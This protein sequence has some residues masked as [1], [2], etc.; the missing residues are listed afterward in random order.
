[1]S[2][3]TRFL[4]IED[5]SSDVELIQRELKKLKIPFNTDVVQDEEALRNSLEAFKPDI[6]LSDYMLPRFTG[7]EALKVVL[8]FDTE[9]PFIIVTGSMNEQTAVECMKAGAWDYV[10][11]EKL[12]KLLPSIQSALA[13]KELLEDKK[14]ALRSLRESEQRYR[15]LIES[16]PMAIVVHLEKK[17]YYANER[18]IRMAGAKELEDM[19]GLDIMT[20]VHPDF[21]SLIETRFTKMLSGETLDTAEEKFIT[22]DGREIPVE[23][24]SMPV[25]IDGRKAFMSIINDISQRKEAMAS[26][27]NLVEQSND[28]I[29]L[30]FKDKFELIN[31][32]FTEMFGYS[33][34]DCRSDD[35]NFLTLIAPESLPLIQ[36][37]IQAQK[38]GEELTKMY[39]FTAISKTGQRIICETSTSHIE[40][41]GG[42][43]TQGI[44]RDI[45]ERRQA[46]EEI[47]KLSL[48]VEQSPNSI[49]I[50]DLEGT[51]EYVNP[52]FKDITGYSN[53]EAIGE[54]PR[55][56]KSAETDPQV[57]VNLWETLTSGQVWNGRFINR[58]KNGEIFWAKAIISP[59]FDLNKKITHYL[60]LQEDITE[61]IQLEEQFRQSQKMEAIGQLAGGVAHDF[62]NLLTIINGYSELIL[63]KTERESPIFEQ[64]QQIKQAGIRATSL[65]RQLLAFSRKQI[66]KPEILNI[67][68]LIKDMEKMLRRLIGEDIDFISIYDKSLRRIKADPGQ[69]EQVILNLVVN[70]RDAMPDGGKLT[71]E[72]MNIQ[73]TESYVGLH[74]GSVHGW[75][76]MIAVSD[77][78]AG[79][80]NETKE[81]IFEPF[82]TTKEQG[83]G[84]GLGLST[85]YGIVQQSGG[86]VW[87]Y[88][89]EGVGTT[90]KIY[91]PQIEEDELTKNKASHNERELSGIETILI[92][93]DEEFVRELVISGLQEFGYQIISAKNREDA[94]K[95]AREYNGKIDLLLTD[96]VMPGGSGGQLAKELAALIPGLKILFMSGYTDES[97]VH[98]GMLSEGTNFIQK[99]FSIE[100]LAEKIRDV[101]D[102]KK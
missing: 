80:D 84:T 68:R 72:T 25:D 81:H 79:M 36:K 3:I 40:Y 22:L 102:E 55:I 17:I 24:T 39:E 4:I 27:R 33:L 69:V 93:E 59:I 77:T 56:L 16:A 19:L 71:I 51:I 86:S 6:V 70:A 88:S 57:Y 66:M 15:M 64:V 90:F 53:E 20:L 76:V 9:L 32:R 54:N 49:V 2:E 98:H 41:E 99:P 78:G 21:V 45:T 74:Q 83:K 60:S 46:E 35:F 87:V 97:I 94:L 14:M 65:T 91:F 58:K 30:L 52:A 92:T 63:S 50:T 101:L 28:A 73:L 100:A 43:A 61:K 11:K 75:F 38:N 1:M 12:S 34:E 29:Y 96:V 82:F 7:M 23:I 89:E 5:L 13:K 10:I 37:R 62:N 31:A 42:L 44:I 67:N 26:F 85:V 95:T 48:A 8:D 47:R 18:A